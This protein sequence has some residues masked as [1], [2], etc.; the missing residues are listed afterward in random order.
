MT[1]EE[2]DALKKQGYSDISTI[3]SSTYC[4][5]EERLLIHLQ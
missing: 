2:I 4:F 5:A 1:K 3:M